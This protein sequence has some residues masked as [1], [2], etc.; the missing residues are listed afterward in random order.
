MAFGAMAGAGDRELLLGGEGLG[1][2]SLY[3]FCPSAFDLLL[4]CFLLKRFSRAVLSCRADSD[5]CQ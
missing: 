5:E 4:H 2:G 3:T 1:M